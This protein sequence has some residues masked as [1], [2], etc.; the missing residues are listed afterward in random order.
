MP[1]IKSILVPVDFSDVAANAFNFALRLADKYPARVDLLYCMPTALSS[2]GMDRILVARAGELEQEAKESMAD[3]R[4]RGI[5]AAMKELTGIPEVCSLIKAGDLEPIVSK[6]IE[7]G[8]VDLIVMGS[9][10]ED[11]PLSNLVGTNTIYMIDEASVPVLIVPD[12]ATYRP[13]SRICYATDLE[14][15][16][17]FQINDVLDLF[18]PFKPDVDFVYVAKTDQEETEYTMDLLRRVV[19]RPD[20][21]DRISFIRL[22]GKNEVDTLLRFAQTSSADLLVMNR[23]RRGWLERLWKKS[24]TREAMLKSEMPLLILHAAESTD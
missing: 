3:F 7:A 6:R 5:D 11:K 23:P 8:E 19:D 1:K 22:R 18:A 17:P 21:H 16:D 9:V 13:P 2:P 12:E 15:L 4:R 10:G 14:H 24:S 20:I